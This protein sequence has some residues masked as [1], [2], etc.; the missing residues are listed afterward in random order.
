MPEPK[1]DKSQKPTVSNDNHDE[2]V[3]QRGEATQAGGNKIQGDDLEGIIP[4]T[5]MNDRTGE[6]RRK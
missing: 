1:T 5:P 6:K 2:N 3:G 4:H